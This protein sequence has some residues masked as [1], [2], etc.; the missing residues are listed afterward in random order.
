MRIQITEDI[1]HLTS[2]KIDGVELN[3]YISE[4]CLTQNA[5]HQPELLLKIRMSPL[6]SLEVDLPEGIVVVDNTR[7]QG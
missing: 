6:D 2:V 5:M 4:F 3:N 1:N 7:D